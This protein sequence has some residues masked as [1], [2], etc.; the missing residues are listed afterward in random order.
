MRTPK[1]VMKLI[2]KRPLGRS[3]RRREDTTKMDLWEMN[4]EDEL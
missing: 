4:V 1:L 3:R 2:T